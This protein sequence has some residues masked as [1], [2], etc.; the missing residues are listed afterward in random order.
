MDWSA[1]TAARWSATP[2]HASARGGLP[3]NF[4]CQIAEDAHHDL[5]IAIKDAGIARWNRGSDTFT[6]YRHDPANAAVPRQRRREHGA[7]RCARPSLDW[8]ARCGSRPTGPRVGAHRTPAPRCEW[9]RLAEQ[10][11]DL[12]PRARP[13][14]D[15]LDRHRGRPRPGA[16]QRRLRALQPPGGRSGHAQRQS[17]FQCARGPRRSALGGNPRWRPHAHGPRWARRASIPS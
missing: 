2:T 4:I 16:A 17:G 1:S 11:P 14:R 15:R 7:G 13:F 10:R 3:G 5:W 8:N 9:S 6:V 12:F